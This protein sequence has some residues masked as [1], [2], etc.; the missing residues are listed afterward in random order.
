MAKI[1][2]ASHHASTLSRPLHLISWPF[3]LQA[4]GGGIASGVTTASLNKMAINITVAGI[5][6]LIARLEIFAILLC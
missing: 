1:Y 5:G 2:P 4:V 6:W 3:F